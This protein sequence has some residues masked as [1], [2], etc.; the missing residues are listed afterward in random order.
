M[1]E[2]GIPVVVAEDLTCVWRGGGKALEMIV[3]ARRRPVQRRVVGYGQ[4][5]PGLSCLSDEVRITL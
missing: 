2:T 5:Y 4:D 1:E 3:Y